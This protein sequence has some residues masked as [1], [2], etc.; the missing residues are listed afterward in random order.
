LTLVG[1]TRPELAT[2]GVLVLKGEGLVEGRPVET[3]DIVFPVGR[4]EIVY[5]FP[6]D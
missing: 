2:T 3:A 4:Y 6:H 1:V 5:R